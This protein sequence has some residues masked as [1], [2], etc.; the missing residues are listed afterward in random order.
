MITELDHITNLKTAAHELKE[1]YK[2]VT[3]AAKEMVSQ[4]KDVIDN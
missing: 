4:I 3:T 2:D 1:Q